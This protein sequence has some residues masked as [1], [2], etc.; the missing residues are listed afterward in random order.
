MVQ[1]ASPPCQSQHEKRNGG[2]EDVPFPLRVQHR[3]WKSF[4]SQPIGQNMASSSS[5]KRVWERVFGLACVQLKIERL[6]YYRKRGNGYGRSTSSLCHTRYIRSSGERHL[7]A[8]LPHLLVCYFSIPPFPA[9]PDS[10]SFLL[11]PCLTICTSKYAMLVYFS[12]FPCN[13]SVALALATD[14]PLLQ[15]SLLA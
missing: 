4:H 13:T 2:E 9:L 15:Y 14:S 11:Q 8:S 6:N 5:R 12:A 10:V 1:D 7:P 3:M